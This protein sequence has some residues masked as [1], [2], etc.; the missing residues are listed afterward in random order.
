MK[1]KDC[2]RK[3]LEKKAAKLGI[4]IKPRWSDAV[5]RK[6]IVASRERAK[7]I[8][9]VE[10]M[11]IPDEAAEAEPVTQTPR[12]KKSKGKLEWPSDWP[13]ENRV[14][15]YNTV[16]GQPIP[17]DEQ[18]ALASLFEVIDAKAAIAEPTKTVLGYSC[19]GLWHDASIKQCS[20]TC[21]IMPLCQKICATRPELREQVEAIAQATD[22][23]A[24]LPGRTLSPTVAKEES[25]AEP[26]VKKRGRP[27]KSDK[28]VEE[29]KPA[30]KV[31]NKKKAAGH[32]VFTG[33]LAEYEDMEG[34][35]EE[36]L[37]LYR[38]MAKPVHGKPRE[39]NFD[40]V[41]KKLS[42][43]YEAPEQAAQTIIDYLIE[44]EDLEVRAS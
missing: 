7:A 8:E 31:K 20:L 18:E 36:V 17:N 19:F 3:Q 41:V 16:V 4:D 23:L 33:D 1:L 44:Q 28:A 34:A 5:L 32:Y 9:T 27:K 37:K 24:D 2:S 21:L 43:S 15:Y 10:A 30:K 22:E 42:D 39:F 38:W 26:A 14:A 11:A 6:E 40:K 29:A 13:E 25:G 12:R 35:D